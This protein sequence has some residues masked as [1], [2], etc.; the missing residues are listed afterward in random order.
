MREYAPSGNWP[1]HR[2]LFYWAVA[3][4]IVTGT[5]ITHLLGAR[6]LTTNDYVGLNDCQ[7]RRE[8]E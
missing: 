1:Y 6:T 4:V 8:G 3:W 7:L 2:V 5:A